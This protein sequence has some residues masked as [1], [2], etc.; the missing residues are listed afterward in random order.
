M[1]IAGPRFKT[2]LHITMALALLCGCQ[3]PETKRKKQFST[4]HVH[5]EVSRETTE[6]TE[7]VP[8]WR[9][10]PFM[11]NVQKSP[12]LTEANVTQA[13]VIEVVGGFALRLQ[14]DHEGTLLL[15]QYSSGNLCKHFAIFSQFASPPDEKLNKGRWLAAPS[16]NK[17]IAN[18]V[19]VFTPDA[20]REETDQIAL[21]L[22][23]LAKKLKK[24]SE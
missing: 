20:T 2:Y 5:L 1:V 11:V 14:F 22:N 23:N 24:T 19:L 13:K 12:F 18:G 9:E 6:R 15:E 8:I 4:L 16:I 17:H 10:H 3:S 21:G 7:L